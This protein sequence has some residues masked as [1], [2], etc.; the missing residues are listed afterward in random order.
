MKDN[1]FFIFK[2]SI[3]YKYLTIFLFILFMTA[4]V[5]CLFHIEIES[6]LLETFKEGNPAARDL[7]FYFDK[8]GKNEVVAFLVR[9]DDGLITSEKNMGQIIKIFNQLTK[10][11]ETNWGGTFYN[12]IVSIRGLPVLLTENYFALHTQ[13]VLESIQNNPLKDLYLSEDK[14]KALIVFSFGTEEILHLRETFDTII[15]ESGL[16]VEYISNQ[17]VYDTLYQSIILSIIYQP[18]AILMLYLLIFYICIRSIRLSLIALI[19][20][21]TGTLLTFIV[22][23]LS[24]TRLNIV[25]VIIP[26]FILLMGAADS[27]HLILR[28]KKILNKTPDPEEALI[29][30]LKLVSAPIILT[31][32]TT[33]AGFLSLTLNDLAVMKHLGIF[34]A[35]GIFFAGLASLFLLPPLI[36]L[37]TQKNA[38]RFATHTLPCE[39]IIQNIL[40]RARRLKPVMFALGV[41]GIVFVFH[42]EIESNQMVFFREYTKVHQIYTEIENSFIT[43]LPF[44]TEYQ[45]GEDEEPLSITTSIISKVLQV[46]E[47]LRNK[48]GISDVVSIFDLFHA[49]K[50]NIDEK[51]MAG[52]TEE[53]FYKLLVKQIQNNFHLDINAWIKGSTVKLIILSRLEDFSDTGKMIDAITS[54]P[55]LRRPGGLADFF[56][57]L[58]D[59]FIYGIFSTISASLLS[60]FLI[61]LLYFK[62]LK[63]PFFSILPVVFTVIVTTGAF[64]LF[65][66]NLNLMT[67]NLGAIIIGLTIDYSIHMVVYLDRFKS[68]DTR[69]ISEIASPIFINA[70]AIILGLLP[71]YFSDLLF[72]FQSAVILT[73]AMLTSSIAC[74]L[75][76]PGLLRYKKN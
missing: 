34:T 55:D 41:T 65:G 1:L 4:G 32:L 75:L 20:V 21:I 45:A 48:E 63:N 52:L 42:L 64:S 15:Q 43:P 31:S 73:L 14:K 60:V 57:N 17:I 50:Q 54:Y 33:M 6:D 5:F 72:H 59:N 10:M 3:K 68:T 13:E 70:L 74:V 69:V 35:I 12:P 2:A 28:Y 39:R 30:A 8:Y 19:P 46:E 62:N 51:Y 76:L 56:T 61:L 71:L 24:G 9:T 53:E 67:V 49:I 58:S 25:L 40:L 27:L 29:K 36:L 11:E 66:F 47:E 16:E 37:I 44:Y 26:I 23:C 22:L 18:P 7:M 38:S